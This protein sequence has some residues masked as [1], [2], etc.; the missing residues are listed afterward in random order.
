MQR[1]QFTRSTLLGA[2]SAPGL[3]NFQSSTGASVGSPPSAAA[4]TTPAS[5][6]GI[7][8]PRVFTGDHLARLSFPLGGIGTGG[9]GL[10]GRGQLRDWQIYNRAEQGYAPYVA[11]ST[12][13][14]QVPGQSMVARV[15]E[16]RLLPPFE[17]WSGADRHNFPGLPRLAEAQFTSRFPLVEVAFTDDTLPVRVTL[18]AFSPFIPHQADESGYP[19]AVLRYT[20]DNTTKQSVTASVAFSLDNPVRAEGR[21]NAFERTAAGQG[22]RMSA[23]P[24]TGGNPAS[25]TFALLMPASQAGEIEHLVGWPGSEWNFGLPFWDAFSTTGRVGTSTDKPSLVGTVNCRQTLA[26]GERKTI[27]FLLAWH[28]PN[29]TPAYSNWTAPKGKENEV[30]GNHYAT[31]FADAW[32]VATH[33]AGH[34]PTLEAQTRQFADALANTTLPGA[35]LDA[36]TAN[37]TTLIS[38][39]CFRT[40]DG[41]FYGYE[42]NMPPHNWGFGNCTHVWNY[43]VA[44]QFLFPDLAR[45]LRDTSFGPTA[46]SDNGLMDFR[47]YV[48]QQQGRFNEAAADGQMGQLMKLY[49]DYKLSG[50]RAWL[51]RHW[52]AAKRALAFA[53]IPNGWDADQDGVMEGVQHNTYDIE[54]YGPN[55]LC[56]V[57]YLGALRAGEEMAKVMQ[58]EA[59]AQ[60][61]RS[62]FERGSWWLDANLFNGEYYVQQV[63]PA[64][65]ETIAP[66]L[67][68]GQGALNPQ[69][70]D[71]QAGAGCLI[72]Q[73]V[74]Q[75][76]ADVSG[77]GDLLNPKHIDQA[78]RSMLRYNAK[79]NLNTHQSVQRAYALNDEA[80]MVIC[81]YTK[82]GRPQK[83]FPYFSEVMTGFE[84]QAAVLMLYRDL[85]ADGLRAIEHIRERYDG[86]KRNAFDEAEYGHN[87]AR[88]MASWA[89]VVA[90][91]GFAYDAPAQ[92]M[93]LTAPSGQQPTKTF[94]STATAWGLLE[95]SPT[96]QQ[97]TLTVLAGTLPIQAVTWQGPAKPVRTVQVNGRG[98]TTRPIATGL[99][100]PNGLQL[101]PND[102]LRLQ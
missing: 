31:R 36:A 88:A 25:G 89:A 46:M 35:V 34:L 55:P 67:R 66:G 59:F 27:T 21:Q 77:L 100:L 3:T 10:G 28:F 2:L 7:T 37:L 26:P 63:K 44:T 60:T 29:R 86:R 47:Q 8:Y 87:Y 54:F 24:L 70:P 43:E 81:D 80:A 41:D 19:V 11:M 38:P 45:S 42:G 58:D 5:A 14:V 92:T 101:S 94:W 16:S 18:E 9:I 97:A 95:Q 75:Y 13:A 6:S 79:P 72:D 99:E 32:A 52:P 84:Y 40:A 85:T 90:L 64:T 53:W 33:V 68:H 73:L 4:S 76:M 23:A 22:L 15:L 83:P 91:S 62:L 71:F 20:L 48:R 56:G 96:R 78:M 61:C 50:D 93:R 74:G 98:L 1:R 57:W 39:T 69:Q 82:G 102:V 12:L 49:L 17:G 65:H 30:I 51:A